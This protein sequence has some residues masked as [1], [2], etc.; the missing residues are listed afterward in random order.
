MSQPLNISARQRNLAVLTMMLGSFIAVLNQTLLATA[1]PDMM[2]SFHLTLSSAQWV[3]TIFMLING[4]MIPISAYLTSNYSTR[5]LYF[6]ATLLFMLGSVLCLVSP[7]FL[8]LLLGRAIQA[9]GAGILIP[10]M[11][12]VLLTAYSVKERGVAMGIFGLITGFSP[13]LGPTL[14]GWILSFYHWPAI[15]VFVLVAML[16]N[17]GV[18][19]FLVKNLTLTNA[20][21]L[22][23]LSVVLS[24]VSFG[25]LLYGF[26]T[27]SRI[28]FSKTWLWGL[29][30]LSLLALF[31]YVRRQK[32]LENPMLDMAVLQSSTFVESCLM[33][34]IMFMI[35]NSS[36]TLMPIY[37]QKIR[38]LTAL[39]SGLIILPGGLLM[40][41]LA[42][43]TGRLYDKWGGKV[44]AVSGM[45][46]ILTGS[47]LLSHLTAASQPY[48][49]VIN[50]MILMTGN[51]FILT[52]LTAKA[53]NALPLALIP[54]GSAM[55]SSSR[56]LFAA[57]GTAVF[58]S[59][60]GMQKTLEAGFQFTYSVI[61]GL[62]A[63]GLFLAVRSKETK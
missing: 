48:I 41:L 37:I 21:Q 19:L 57:I 63:L 29:I 58:V 52:P 42:P 27:A 60:M 5:Q 24:T 50:F 43:I 23:V 35:F 10:L 47:L 7:T 16:L 22:D 44:F 4:I 61:S 40:G 6:T 31:W 3:T 13:A 8:L 25:G 56:Q 9:I 54:H 49:I 17:V 51:A 11:Q 34:I 62:A 12:V 2:V 39:Q 26:S 55:N 20:S 38:G 59:I 36:M 1:L 28:G 33:I 46:L 45:L 32:Q 18:S 30:G 15:F 14:A 53:M